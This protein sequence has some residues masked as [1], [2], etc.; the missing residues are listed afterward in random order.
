MNSAEGR[1]TFKVRTFPWPLDTK[2]L[3]LASLVCQFTG[4]SPS[5]CRSREVPRLTTTSELPTTLELNLITGCLHST[6]MERKHELYEFMHALTFKVIE[7][8]IK[9]KLIKIN[10]VAEVLREYFCSIMCFLIDNL[11]LC[12]C[13]SHFKILRSRAVSSAPWV[14]FILEVMSW[15]QETDWSLRS[16]YHPSIPL[17]SAFHN[18]VST[19]EI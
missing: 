19:L 1:S 11:K 12:F 3:C 15:I 10:Y 8:Q 17:A 2:R 5:H 7:T 16:W 9:N 18:V 13:Y 14:C 4:P 6:E